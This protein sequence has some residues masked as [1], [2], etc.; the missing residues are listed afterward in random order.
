MDIL[1]PE[2]EDEQNDSAL[3]SAIQSAPN[4]VLAAKIS[5]SPTGNLWMDPQPRFAAQ[6]K[7]WDMYRL[8]SI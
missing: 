3:A 4:I 8:S 1:L 2:L 6:P 5:T 7:A